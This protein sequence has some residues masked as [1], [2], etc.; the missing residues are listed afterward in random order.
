MGRG[1]REPP[2]LVKAGRS[3]VV[4]GGPPSL[5]RAGRGG[6]IPTGVYGS[7]CSCR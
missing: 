7:S 5:I 1:C 4:G 6:S 2:S 3:G